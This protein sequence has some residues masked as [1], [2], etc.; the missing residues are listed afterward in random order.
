MPHKKPIETFGNNFPKRR[1]KERDKATGV[2]ARDPGSAWPKIDL[3][4][5]QSLPLQP[6][7]SH[8]VSLSLVAGLFVSRNL[9]EIPVASGV[10]PAPVIP[11]AI[12]RLFSGTCESDAGGI[13]ACFPNLNY[14]KCPPIRDP[15]WCESSVSTILNGTRV[16]PPA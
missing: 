6:A 5:L 11:W 16:V 10:V 13:V 3:F 2:G 12:A 14:I 9:P 1:E 15:C 8:E 4:P 7:K